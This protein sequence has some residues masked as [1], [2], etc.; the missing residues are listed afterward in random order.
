MSNDHLFLSIGAMKA[1]TTWLHQ[2]LASHRDIHFCP[3]KEIHYFADPKGEN[4]MSATGRVQRYQQVVKNLTAD[5]LNSHVQRNLSWYGSHY[6]GPEVND[7]WYTALFEVRA[8]V[9]K[10]A[11]YVADFSNLYATLDIEG[12]DHIRALYQNV[13]AIYTM[14]HPA[15]RMWSHFKFDY[16]FKGHGSELNDINQEK[17]DQFLSEPGFVNHIDYAGTVERLRNILLPEQI[18]FFFFENF[19]DHPIENLQAIEKFLDIAPG[20]YKKEKFE[21]KINPSSGIDVPKIFRD[22]INPIHQEQC[23]RLTAQGFSLPSSW[24]KPL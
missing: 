24:S 2:Q 10:N 17:I 11:K 4:Y 19:R 16:E 14:R 9:K 20:E 7:D 18:E 13:R 23:E 22:A 12:W 3:E 21:K 1:G 5:R 6:L 15:K 8:P